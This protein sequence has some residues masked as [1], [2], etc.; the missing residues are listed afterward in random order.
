MPELEKDLDN[1][2]R[3]YDELTEEERKIDSSIDELNR[4]IKT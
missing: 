2:R 4:Q 3:K 1:L